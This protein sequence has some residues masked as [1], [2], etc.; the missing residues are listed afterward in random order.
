MSQND[1]VRSYRDL[2][3]RAK[4]MDAA[5][6]VLTVIDEGPLARKYRLAGQF[7]AAATSVPANIAEGKELGTT[8][9]YIKHLYYARGSLAEAETFAEL[10]HRRSYVDQERYTRLMALWL[11]V[12]KMLNALI[13]KLENRL[14]PK[15]RD[16]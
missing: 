11:E 8:K 7:E 14:G 4:A 12:G 16:L 5:D 9:Q 13:T 2:K 15:D 6:L 1:V 10:F 3:V